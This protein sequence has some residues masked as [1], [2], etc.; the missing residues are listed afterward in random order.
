MQTPLKQ[1]WL[2]PMLPAI[3]IL[4]AGCNSVEDDLQRVVDKHVEEHIEEQARKVTTEHAKAAAEKLARQL[5]QSNL[6]DK[7]TIRQQIV[8]TWQDSTTNSADTYTPDGTYH[9]KI[10]D[11][12]TVPIDTTG[13]IGNVTT[14][15]I[16]TI[17]G[18]WSVDGDQL[19]VECTDAENLAF[20]D[21]S[22][23]R[24]KASK[25]HLDLAP[26]QKKMLEYFQNNKR[27]HFLRKVTVRIVAVSDEKL[28]TE[29]K[30]GE[31]NEGTRVLDTK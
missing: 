31:L 30:D 25:I 18:T 27:S 13:F 6:S 16:G 22:L 2:F 24:T 5:V 29:S 28:V 4:S 14:R 12:I 11:I 20:S 10:D 8:G 23:E 19:T 9:G 15:L 3:I 26:M 21:I 1:I 7:P 17:S